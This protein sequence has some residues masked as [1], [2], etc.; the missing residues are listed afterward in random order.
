[1]SPIW[2]HNEGNDKISGH[3]MRNDHTSTP[4]LSESAHTSTYCSSLVFIRE[5][6]TWMRY[7]KPL[8]RNF[9]NKLRISDLHEK[10]RLWIKVDPEP[11]AAHRRTWGWDQGY[12]GTLNTM[13][14]CKSRSN[15]FKLVKIGKIWKTTVQLQS[16]VARVSPTALRPR[17]YE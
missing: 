10:L 3:S 11:T 13:V 5:C 1:M 16:V 8:W 4:T 6:E 9:T 7:P 15:N 12:L 17:G 14:V 2:L